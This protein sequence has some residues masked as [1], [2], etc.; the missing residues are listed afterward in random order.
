MVIKR[1]DSRSDHI[2]FVESMLKKSEE[3]ETAKPRSLYDSVDIKKIEELTREL[4]NKAPTSRK[5]G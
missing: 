4:Q 5:K 2:S 3:K 1:N